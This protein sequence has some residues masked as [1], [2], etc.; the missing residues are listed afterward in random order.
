[1]KTID[2]RMRPPFGGYRNCVG[3]RPPVF[4]A[5][6]ISMGKVPPA[7]AYAKSMDMLLSEMEQAEIELAVVHARKSWGV[8]NQQ[9]VDLITNYAGKF[10]GIANLEP[11]EGTAACLEELQQYVIEGPLKGILMETATSKQHW[12]ADDEKLYPIYE[13]CQ[14]HHK[15]VMLTV[16]G[17]MQI[18]P[19]Y[20]EAEQVDRLAAD[21]PDLKII[22]A[23]AGYPNVL[24]MCAVAIKRS[25]VYLLP[26]NYFVNTPG[27]QLYINAANYRLQDKMLFGSSYPFLSVTEATNHYYHCGLR[28]EVLPKIMY[29]NAAY[30]LGMIT[31]VDQDAA[32]VKDLMNTL[33][34]DYE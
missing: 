19:Q 17:L 14:K 24:D 3:F 15:L 9:I 30:L 7:S 27:D 2:F 6:S 26:D 11:D 10:V 28:A 32:K 18:D 25:N 13:Q 31:E 23:H 4:E 8:S 5:K 33:S 12:L 29:R 20:Y 34:K 16:G 1:M 21:F 22:V